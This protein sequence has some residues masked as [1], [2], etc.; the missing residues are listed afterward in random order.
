ME[1]HFTDI[2]DVEFTANMEEKLD[3]IEDGE[4]QWKD[5]IKDFYTPFAKTLADA[6]EAIGTV[7]IQDEV[8]DVPCDKCGRMMVSK[9][10]RFG[11][12]L[13]CPGYPECKN[14][15]S[16]EKEVE[17]PCPICGSKVYARKSRKGMSYYVCEKGQECFIS[18]DEPT[19]ISC[20]QCSAYMVKRRAFRGKGPLKYV[21][22]NE[23]CK[24]EELVNKKVD[25]K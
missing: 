6:E 24:Y 12:F 2:V 19:K 21:C 17:A 20:P 22:S 11:K 16:I 14:T 13:A 23:N 10:G 4:K 18:W 1:E 3:H 8:S 9:Q 15:K 7:E 25:K 5:I